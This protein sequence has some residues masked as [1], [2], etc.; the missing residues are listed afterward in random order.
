VLPLRHYSSILRSH[1]TLSPESSP[2]AAPTNVAIFGVGRWGT[3]LLRNFLALPSARVIAIADP[4]PQCL[5]IARQRF[6]LPPTV[7]CLTDWAAALALPE[8]EAVVVAT[9]A[10]THYPLIKAALEGGLH[11]LTE[12]PMT[13]EPETCLE[14]CQLA[15]KQQRSLVVD[16]TYLFHPAVQRGQQV[17]QTGQLGDLRYGYATRTNLGPVRYD[18]DAL[19]DLA[20]HDIAVLNHWLS[21]RPVTVAAQGTT[22][23]QPQG[24]ALTPQPLP[25]LGW[26]TLTYG[27]GFQAVIHV[28][29]LNPDKQRRLAI[30]GSQGTLVFD[31]MQPE[32]MLTL[33]QGHFERS[34]E[35]YFQP[36][37]LAQ[38]PCP[39][40][41]AEPLQQV[42]LHFLA[43]LDAPPTRSL[44][45]GYVAADLVACQRAIADSLAHNGRAIPVP[46]P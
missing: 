8:L 4:D 39:I 21:D 36:A 18:V 23:L 16:H 9:P 3:H 43:S 24:T 5:A 40:E 28:S 34:A 38:H 6:E 20:I 35:G 46:Y 19:W 37:G 31:E 29:W 14:L 17:L 15:E 22:W 42:C 2:Q 12:K 25:D 10:T 45:S 41:P 32:A 13:L 33:H 1:P 44:S 30:V 26:I 27:T 11:V 7:Q